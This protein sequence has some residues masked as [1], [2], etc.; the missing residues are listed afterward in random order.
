MSTFV[1]SSERELTFGDLSSIRLLLAILTVLSVHDWTIVQGLQAAGAK[2]SRSF[3]SIDIRP[4]FPYQ[5]ESRNLLFSHS[6]E[7]SGNPPLYFALSLP[8][9]LRSLNSNMLS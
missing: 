3:R 4:T 1:E 6:T 2:V 9:R 5:V 7:T 8:R